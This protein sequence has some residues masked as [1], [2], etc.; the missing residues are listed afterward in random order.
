MRNIISASRIFI[1]AS[2]YD[3]SP[4]GVSDAAALF[5]RVPP[6]GAHAQYNIRFADIIP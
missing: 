2:G 5:Q 4:C 3:K 6:E 1:I